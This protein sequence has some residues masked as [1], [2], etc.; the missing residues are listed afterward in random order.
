MLPPPPPSLPVSVCNLYRNP[1]LEIPPYSTPV[2]SRSTI[3]LLH[4]VTFYLQ[5]QGLFPPPPPQLRLPVEQNLLCRQHRFP[6]I[7]PRSP[8]L[9]LS[10]VAYVSRLAIC[11]RIVPFNAPC[12]SSMILARHIPF[13]PHHLSGSTYLVR[14]SSFPSYAFNG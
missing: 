6:R 7:C 3:T 9:P 8:P 13:S 14:W 4:L 11:S 5:G 12:L 1:L 10:F 2:S